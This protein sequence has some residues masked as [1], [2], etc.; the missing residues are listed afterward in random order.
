[1]PHPAG[2]WKPFPSVDCCSMGYQGW[3][4][5]FDHTLFDSDASEALAFATAM[6]TNDVVDSCDQ[7]GL[8]Q[9]F[10]IYSAIN[11]S[12]WDDVEAGRRTPNEVRGLR[13]ERL[14]IDARLDAD[15]TA[16]AASFTWG[17]QEF[18][19]LYPG[20]H[21]VIGALR[22]RGPV[23]LVTN[24][25]SEIQ[26]RRIERVGLAELFD[27]IVIS[28]EVGVAKPAPAIF[29]YA[30]S[31]LA[32]STLDGLEPAATLMVGDSLTSDMAGGRAAGLAT[33][34]YNPE[35]KPADEHVPVD[36]DVQQLEQLLDL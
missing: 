14:A 4:F 30:F 6:E 8:D 11:R 9:I 34:W 35:G 13:F 29:E 5:D 18:G 17:M 26:R 7:L 12:L 27:A 32:G 25:I 23:A 22:E 15:P 24:A 28:S 16:L 33:C 1:M 19:E 10:A 3:F 36:H 21:D 31:M 2:M 20:V